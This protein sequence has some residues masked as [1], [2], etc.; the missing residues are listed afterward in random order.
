VFSFQHLLVLQHL[1]DEFSVYSS[2][3]RGCNDMNPGSEEGRTAFLAPDFSYAD[4]RKSAFSNSALA[5]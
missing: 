2:S 4:S 3:C 1:S 5:H